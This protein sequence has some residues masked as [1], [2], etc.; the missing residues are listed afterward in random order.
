MALV[1]SIYRMGPAERYYFSR[2]E[3][4]RL[5]RGQVSLL[6]RKHGQDDVVGR[7]RAARRGRDDLMLSWLIQMAE[8]VKPRP[9]ASGTL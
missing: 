9:G 1:S 4:E 5:L 8:A 6:V 2:A 3:R 7:L